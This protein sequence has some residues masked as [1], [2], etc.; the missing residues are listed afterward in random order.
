[1]RKIPQR[2]NIFIYILAI[3]CDKQ[4]YIGIDTRA[5]NTAISLPLVTVYNTVNNTVN[6]CIIPR[7]YRAQHYTYFTCIYNINIHT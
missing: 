3:L 4:Y 6:T 7:S 1:M 5:L 2:K